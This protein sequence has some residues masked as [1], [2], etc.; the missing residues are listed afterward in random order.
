MHSETGAIARVGPHLHPAAAL[1]AGVGAL[2]SK[3]NL[4]AAGR[5]R[6]PASVDAERR[7]AFPPLQNAK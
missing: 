6:A 7:S 5:H 1:G 4:R 3:R 2:G